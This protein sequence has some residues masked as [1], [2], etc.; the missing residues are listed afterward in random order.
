MQFFF[1]DLRRA[2]LLLTVKKKDVRTC[3]SSALLSLSLSL[4]LSSIL[5]HRLI[6]DSYRNNR[7]SVVGISNA[8]RKNG[9]GC[10][11]I[12]VFTLSYYISSIPCYILFVCL[13]YYHFLFQVRAIRQQEE[14]ET[15]TMQLRLIQERRRKL[16]EGL[17]QR[18][19]VRLLLYNEK[20]TQKRDCWGEEWEIE[21]KIRGI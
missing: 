12:V 8:W 19:L 9:S 4:S 21:R 15:H 13:I 17:L 18:E 3:I 6:S 14:H 2:A 7:I 10:V 20:R 11:G 1:I 5:L 16:E